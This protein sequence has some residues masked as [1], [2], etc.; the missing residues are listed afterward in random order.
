MKILQ[1][2]TDTDR[3]GAQVFA[4]DLGRELATR[5]HAVE[6]VALAP[7]SH[8]AGLDIETLGAARLRP[9]TLRALR[10]RSRGADVVIAHG[11][12]TLPAC[13]LALLGRRPPFVYRQISDSLFW[14]PTRRRQARVRVFLAR[15]KRIVALSASTR[16][17]LVEH[18]GALPGRVSVVPNAVPAA[19]FPIVDRASRAAARREFALTDECLVVLSISAL[20]PEKGVDLDIEAVAGLDDPRVYLLVVG[21]GPQ[22][23]ELAA[24]ALRRL[25]ERAV[26]TGPLV[27]TRP[28]YA[29]ADVMMLASRGGDSM[30]ATILEAAFSGVAVVATPVGAIT[31]VVVDGDTGVVVPVDDVGGLTAALKGLFEDREARAALALRARGRAL[32]YFEIG[33]VA[34]K[35]ETVLEDVVGDRAR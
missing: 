3:R 10:R 19:P 14:A 20:V 33:V 11:S 6:T 23:S 15:A 27:D 35:W 32:E 9:S 30:P 1:V 17:V 8:A 5:G 31:E 25:G 4:T 34:T 18:F 22:R 2:V 21:D 24:H 28:A 13:S 26:F 7:G 29:A 16:D 12:S